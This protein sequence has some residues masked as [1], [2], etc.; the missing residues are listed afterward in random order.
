MYQTH[1]VM[2]PDAGSPDEE[3]H[4]WCEEKR[5]KEKMYVIDV[6]QPRLRNI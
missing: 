2:R 4:P 6:S 5:M 1:Q 3:R